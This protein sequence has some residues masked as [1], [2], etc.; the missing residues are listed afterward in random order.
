MLSWQC[1]EEDLLIQ[2][3]AVNTMFPLGMPS[4]YQTPFSLW[5]TYGFREFRAI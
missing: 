4:K 3:Q 1:R 5:F 2:G